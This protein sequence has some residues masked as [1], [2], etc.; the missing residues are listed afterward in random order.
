MFKRNVYHP[1]PVWRRRI[2]D[3]DGD[4]IEDIRTFSYNERD[5]YYNPL[6]YGDVGNIENTHNGGLPGFDTL[7]FDIT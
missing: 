7:E 3:K 2:T 6:V 5:E 4:G 1:I